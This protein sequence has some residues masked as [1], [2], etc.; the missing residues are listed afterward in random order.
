[1]INSSRQRWDI[2]QNAAM[3]PV[4]YMI[5]G[6]VPPR[7]QQESANDAWR[8]LG[9]ELGFQWDSVRPTGTGDRFFTAVP[10]TKRGAA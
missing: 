10:S 3:K 1:M 5:V 2:G 6:G 8:A 4:P 7:S 9:E